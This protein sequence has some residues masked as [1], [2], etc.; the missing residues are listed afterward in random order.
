MELV[1]RKYD[2]VTESIC[3]KFFG[4]ELPPHVTLSGTLRLPI[5]HP[6][7]DAQHDIKIRQQLR[8]LTYHPENFLD[9][10]PLN[11][12]SANLQDADILIEKKMSWVKTAK[13]KMNAAQRHREIETANE[14]LQ[15]WV[16][17]L[18]SKWEKEYQ[19]TIRQIRANQLLESREYPFC[20]FPQEAL[21]NFLLDF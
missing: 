15:K 8:E 21:R 5:G 2:Q 12:N 10:I 4:F 3:E 18:R 7:I 16:A 9:R 11:M 19:E 1:D 17:P 20:L 6:S 13:N 14:A